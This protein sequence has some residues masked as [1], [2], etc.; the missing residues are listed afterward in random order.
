MRLQQ[1]SIS[2]LADWR[3]F[4]Q[5]V[6]IPT[7]V[8]GPDGDAWAHWLY[9]RFGLR[10]YWRSSQ[11]TPSPRMMAITKEMLAIFER[12]LSCMDAINLDYEGQFSAGSTNT[13]RIRRPPRFTEQTAQAQLE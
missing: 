11:A 4:S 3:Y 6:L 13:V 2:I 1:L 12:E 10:W 9:G 8:L 5:L 7:I